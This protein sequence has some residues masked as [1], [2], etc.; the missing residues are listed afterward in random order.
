MTLMENEVATIVQMRKKG[1][2]FSYI[3]E[4]AQRGIPDD[5][6]PIDGLRSCLYQSAE[7]IY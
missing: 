4:N 3:A 5:S 2:N 1:R 7:T 6:P